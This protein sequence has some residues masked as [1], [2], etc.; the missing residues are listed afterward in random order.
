MDK[1]PLLRLQQ[2]N[3]FPRPDTASA[4]TEGDIFLSGGTTLKGFGKLAGAPATSWSSGGNLNTGRG[5]LANG[6]TGS[7]S[8]ASLAFGGNPYS[9]ANELYDGT[10]WTESADLNTGTQGHGGGGNSHIGN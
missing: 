9:T 8:S 1:L 10:S 5:G 2:K 6:S 3:F 7:S 4:L